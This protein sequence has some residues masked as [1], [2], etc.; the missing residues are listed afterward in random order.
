MG[1]S[2]EVVTVSDTLD[3]YP[4][5]VD[6][7]SAVALD[8]VSLLPVGDDV[9]RARL[10][11]TARQE[12]KRRLS[13]FLKRDTPAWNPKDHPEIDAAGGAAAWVRKLRREAEEGFERRTRNRDRE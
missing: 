4:F 2:G 6:A 3:I 8:N 12:E 10:A 9:I 1:A 13:E 7:Q 5:P 11:D